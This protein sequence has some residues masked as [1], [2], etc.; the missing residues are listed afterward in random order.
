VA[1]P[2][3]RLSSSTAWLFDQQADRATLFG[4]TPLMRHNLG[5]CVINDVSER[6]YQLERGARWGKGY[7]TFSPI[8]PL[9]GD[10]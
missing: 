9:A 8:V 6:E 10:A 4:S 7:D 3:P 5:Y 2:C 1:K